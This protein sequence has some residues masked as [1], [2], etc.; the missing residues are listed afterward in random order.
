MRSVEFHPEAQAELISAARFFEGKTVYRRFPTAAAASAAIS[1]VCSFPGF[2]TVFSI[3][4]SLI[5]W[6]LSTKVIWTARCAG[7]N[8]RG[9]V[10]RVIA[11]PLAR[12]RSR[13]NG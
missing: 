4:S 5:A 2:R 8:G 9:M 1:G 13:A 11:Q 6:P 3:G 12:Q 10:G 7:K